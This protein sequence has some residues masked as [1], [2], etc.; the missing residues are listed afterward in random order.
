[1]TLAEIVSEL[2]LEVEAGSSGKP[3][4]AVEI[5]NLQKIMPFLIQMP[6]I[7]PQWLAK[8][9]LRRMDDKADMVEAMAAGMPSI[10]VQNQMQQPGTGDP[11]TSPEAQ[12]GQGPQN[13]PAGPPEEMRGSEPAFGSN[14]T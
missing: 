8:E 3:N 1:M 5:D 12:G 6:N 13:A 7:N 14:Q 4:Q 9:M 10:M 11:A 2:Y